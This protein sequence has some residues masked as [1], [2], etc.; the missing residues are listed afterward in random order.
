VSGRDASRHVPVHVIGSR[1][2]VLGRLQEA[3]FHFGLE[4]LGPAIGAMHQLV[5]MP[6]DA[7]DVG[8]DES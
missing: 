2:P 6:L 7:F 5:P 3:G 8:P 1:Q 4:P